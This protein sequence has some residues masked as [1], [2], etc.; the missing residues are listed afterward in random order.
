MPVL[1]EGCAKHAVSRAAP[2]LPPTRTSRRGHLQRREDVIVRGALAQQEKLQS[3]AAAKLDSPLPS[4][5]LSASSAALVAV[6][7]GAAAAAVARSEAEA[8]A[9]R[10]MKHDQ[11]PCLECGKLHPGRDDVSC[12]AEGPRHIVHQ[13]GVFGRRSA[14]R[15]PVG[16]VCG[17]GVRRAHLRRVARPEEN[18]RT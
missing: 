15:G 1:T 2:S 11:V 3:I 7:G 4:S 12:E 18:V 17:H 6:D 10:L 13:K 16:S 14:L 9:P 5:S 8:V